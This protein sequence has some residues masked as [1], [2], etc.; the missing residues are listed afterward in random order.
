MYS[1]PLH[2]HVIRSI[3]RPPKEVIE[4]LGRFDAFESR[5]HPEQARARAE[6]FS[7]ERFRTAFRTRVE[8]LLEG[9]PD[10]RERLPW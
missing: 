4:A 3:I 7:E 8:A 2:P 10:L 6:E 5:F 9:R 1:Q